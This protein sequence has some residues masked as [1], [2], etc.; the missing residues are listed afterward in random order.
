VEGCGPVRY[1]PL[2]AQHAAQSG[3]PDRIYLRLGLDVRTKVLVVATAV[4]REEAMGLLI[5]LGKCAAELGQWFVAFKSHPALSL[6]HEFVRLV[7]VNLG[8]SRYRILE[9]LEELYDSLSVAQ[10][11]VL[12]HSTVTF[13][14]LMLGVLPIVFDSGAVFDPKAMEPHEWEGVSARNAEELRVA[15]RKTTRMNG[16]AQPMKERL[17]TQAGRWFDRPDH[18]PYQRFID[19]L[20]KHGVLNAQVAG[21]R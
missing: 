3:R 8:S 6:E 1:R 17:L 12:N 9:S 7:G 5:A 4:S 10:A 21:Q 15:L 20:Q 18:D 11:V 13:E 16:E 19:I 14:S 2:I